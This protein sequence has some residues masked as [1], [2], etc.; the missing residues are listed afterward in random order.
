MVLKRAVYSFD[1]DDSMVFRIIVLEPG[2]VASF[3]HLMILGV[4]EPSTNKR[5]GTR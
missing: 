1:V 4:T 3:I 2:G 5:A